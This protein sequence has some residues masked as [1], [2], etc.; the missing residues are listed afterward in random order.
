M[1]K[2]NKLSIKYYLSSES[3]DILVTNVT[4]DFVTIKEVE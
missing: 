3:N 1:N 2:I 4:I